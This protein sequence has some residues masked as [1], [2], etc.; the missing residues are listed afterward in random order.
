MSI[1]LIL[2]ISLINLTLSDAIKKGL[3]ENPLYLQ[4]KK[5]FLIKQKNNAYFYSELLPRISGGYLRQKN[6]LI[7]DGVE[8][9]DSTNRYYG[10]EMNWDLSPNEI[11][12]AFSSHYDNSSIFFSFLELRDQAIY[13]IISQYLNTLKLDKLFE[14]RKRAVERTENNLKLIEE[15]KELGAASFAEV[16]QGKVNNL[17]AQLEFME[18]KKNRKISLLKLKKLIGLGIGDSV[19]LEEPE[20]DFVIPPKDSIFYLAERRDP[21]INE[22]TSELI[23][24]RIDF[25][26]VS[27]KNFFSFSF[28]TEWRYRDKEFP[29]L[30]FLKDNYNYS[31]GFSISIPLFT[32]FSRINEITKAQ[33][34]MDLAFLRL[35]ERE[36]E[37]RIL[38]EENY[39]LYEESQ[40]K[41]ELAQTALSFAEENYKA[42][43]ERYRLGE[44]SIIEL[45]GA[46]EDLLKAQ[47]YLTEARFDWYLS[48]Y[49]L[50]KLMGELYEE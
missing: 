38:V 10:V 32:G 39:L 25:L 46:E 18:T 34:I 7:L 31:I 43:S 40:K 26:N 50:R 12:N 29:N 9:Y 28:G 1:L 49:S 48:I 17:E 23:K 5:E 11:F 15:K 44:A 13:E 41:L 30:D 47:Y 45:L 33:L 22:F 6:N 35:K 2:L 42:A 37:L 14:S 21:L 3:K 24:A 36:K 27:T 16:L 19:L 8:V 20:I 4:A